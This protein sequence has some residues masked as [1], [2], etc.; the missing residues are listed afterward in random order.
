M[1]C[2]IT[3]FKDIPNYQYDCMNTKVT[4]CSNPARNEFNDACLGSKSGVAGGK[5]F[6]SFEDV[7][8]KRN[9]LNKHISLKMD[10]EGCEYEALKYLSTNELDTIDL[11]IIK[12]HFDFLH[13]EEW[14][15]LDLLRTLA[16][17]FVN[18]NCHSGK[19]GNDDECAPEAGK[20]NLFC[21]QGCPLLA[22]QPFGM[23][24]NSERKRINWAARMRRRIQ[25]IEQ[26]E[27]KVLLFREKRNA[28][29]VGEGR[30]Y[31]V[32]S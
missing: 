32:T 9:P 22:Q 1:G 7:L 19:V 17:K 25:T 2:L 11:L 8:K 5:K 18:V 30:K 10:C 3:S 6:E 20:S 16:S 28:G 26:E 21:F 23:G 27:E 15:D 4:Q 24:E 13:Q 29:M 31:R 14:G 12:F